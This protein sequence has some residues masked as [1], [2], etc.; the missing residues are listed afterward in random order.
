MNGNAHKSRDILVPTE[1]TD[2]GMKHMFYAAEFSRSVGL[3]RNVSNLVF[4][5][6]IWDILLVV[7]L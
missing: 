6:E 1:S 7:I 2:V 4:S 3:D 5:H